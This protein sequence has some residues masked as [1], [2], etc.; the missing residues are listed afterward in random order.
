VKAIFLADKAAFSL[1]LSPGK[2]AKNMVT[3]GLEYSLSGACGL[4]WPNASFDDIPEVKN[5]T[6][7]AKTR[8]NDVFIKSIL[9]DISFFLMIKIKRFRLK[10][11]KNSIDKINFFLTC[12]NIMLKILVYHDF[13]TPRRAFST[14]LTGKRFLI[15]I[16]FGSGS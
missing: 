7:I 6:T 14:S 11:S 4:R 5:K 3:D 16:L 2:V 12:K 13:P 9:V 8:C 1:L 10:H 15:L